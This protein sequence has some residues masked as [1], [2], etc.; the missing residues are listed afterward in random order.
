[1]KCKISDRSR[2]SDLLTVDGT[3]IY[4]FELQ[5]RVTYKQC[6]RKS[7]ARPAMVKEQKVW[8][9]SFICLIFEF[10]LV[11]CSGFKCQS[12]TRLQVSSI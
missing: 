12:S 7:Q 6:L 5:R 1:M 2:I 8:R 11:I 9:K 3:W 10:L 4:E